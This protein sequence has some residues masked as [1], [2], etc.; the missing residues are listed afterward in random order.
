M[1]IVPVRATA[2][3]LVALSCTLTPKTI[4]LSSLLACS[5][6]MD[7][8]VAP[9]PEVRMVILYTERARDATS[10]IEG[11]IEHAV[12]E[13]NAVL[14]RSGI[15]LRTVL[16]HS[17]LL[18]GVNEGGV[19]ALRDALLGGAGV[20]AKAH[21]LRDI[22]H[23][24][25]VGLVADV[26][27]GAS[28]PMVI[29]SMAARDKAFLAMGWSYLGQQFTLAHELGH[30]LGGV[31][32][33]TPPNPADLPRYRY[34]FPHFSTTGWRTLMG[35]GGTRI[36]HFSNP[37]VIYYDP[38]IPGDPGEPTGTPITDALPEDNRRT[39]SSTGAYVSFFRLTPAW[40]ASGGGATPWFEKRAA[41]ESIQ[42]VRF[43]NLDGDEDGET[44]AIKLDAAGGW[45]ISLGAS[46]PW[47]TLRASDPLKAP[48]EELRFAD[49][50]KDGAAD[51]FYVD[52]PNGQW[53]VWWGKSA[54]TDGWQVLNSGAA[55]AAIGVDE[56]AFG[57]F[58][59]DGQADV[60]RSDLSTDTW[61]YMS[62]GTG[63]WISLG[64]ADPTKKIPTKDLRIGNF[65]GDNASSDVF[66]A[67]VPT[68]TWFIS[69]NG[70]G[71][72]ATL[73]TDPEA[74]V[75]VVNLLFGDFDG[76]GF[77]DVVKASGSAW[78]VSWK[79]QNS[80]ELLKLSCSIAT[81][82]ALGDF[83]GDGTT[84]IIRAGIRP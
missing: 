59:G 35:T 40:F 12:L 73:L 84:D 62:A 38:T 27:A 80:P 22:W 74:N 81:N 19:I 3:I 45:S 65:D 77:T 32:T 79:G 29:P 39:M 69:K 34:A 25:V 26:V 10:D 70:T 21:A 20:F 24:D 2:A 6:L 15:P 1:R 8:S 51:V 11:L 50:N 61:F 57:D 4:E 18:P 14:A 33:R 72:W 66:R 17:E 30:L 64:P 52:V 31:H 44:D 43:A 83:D 7:M 56:L 58:N 60:F 54:P 71:A 49:F 46:D 76:D 9:A 55:I 63:S 5:D 48:L 53:L 42:D 78:G 47:K 68:N 67:D 13:T 23:G 37:D 36:W 41:D 82:V 16:A 75:P 28:V